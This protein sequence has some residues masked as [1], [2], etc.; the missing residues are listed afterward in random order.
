VLTTVLEMGVEAVG[1][2]EGELAFAVVDT[3]TR[4]V[5]LGRDFFGLYPIYYSELGPRGVAFASEYKA[6]LCLAEV[7][8]TVDL[9]MLQCL[10]D[11]KKMPG[12]RT[13]LRSVK[14]PPPGC[15]HS[16]RSDGRSQTR[17]VSPPVVVDEDSLIRSESTA[18]RRLRDELRATVER[19]ANDL[20]PI[21]L[22][23]SGGIDSMAL[24]F[25]LRETYPRRAIH[26]FSAGHGPDDPELVRA[27]E[28][29]SLIKSI[30]HEVVV[31]PAELGS[32]LPSMVWHLEDPIAR[33][34]A[35]QLFEI[36][37]HASGYVGV[38]LVGQGSDS[39]FTGMPRHRLLWFMS[40]LPPVRASLG[41]L[42]DQTQYSTRPDHFLARAV[43]RIY[44]DRKLGIAPR[45]MGIDHPPPRPTLPPPGREFVNRVLAD[46]FQEGQCQ[47]APKYERTFG[48]WG[49]SFRGPYCD[50]GLARFAFTISDRLKI[51]AAERKVVLRRA[52][53]SVVPQ[54]LLATPKAP[55]RIRANREFVAV[56][57][58]L[59][60]TLLSET[61][62]RDRGMFRYED[63]AAAITGARTRPPSYERVMRLWTLILTELWA[64]AFLDHRGSRKR[65][66]PEVPD[67]E[68]VASGVH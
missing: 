17:S 52:L 32:I 36:G 37:R 64:Q 12:G 33:T 41:E 56:L 61:A 53:R 5:T 27:R 60:N 1:T 38:V 30:H 47:E 8:A 7:D 67:P 43:S 2:I 68:P 3:T 58:R 66:E 50:V 31:S 34:E 57:D 46:G 29:S 25:L 59:A 18:A 63:V 54:S 42:Y 24:A 10:Q 51:H 23:L 20:D 45:V 26:T 14:T 16:S 35:A 15:I 65:S 44:F 40:R 22:A 13:L 28:A 9:E 4:E 19:H 55:Q 62:V 48:A 6:L 39:L 21:G 11:W 49:V